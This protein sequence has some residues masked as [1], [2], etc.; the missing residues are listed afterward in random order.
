[1]TAWPEERTFFGRPNESPHFSSPIWDDQPAGCGWLVPHSFASCVMKNTW[2]YSMFTKKYLKAYLMFQKSGPL[3]VGQVFWKKAP[4]LIFVPSQLGNRGF[5]HGFIPAEFWRCSTE[6][7]LE[8][9][10]SQIHWMKMKLPYVSNMT[11][12]PSIFREKKVDLDNFQG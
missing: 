7:T 10:L 1:M 9:K 12:W 3:A 8:V 5:Y 11:P 2:G 6:K 4:F